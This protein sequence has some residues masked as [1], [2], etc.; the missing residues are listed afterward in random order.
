[1]RRT[2]ID[3]MA[4]KNI[5]IKPIINYSLHNHLLSSVLVCNFLF[6]YRVMSMV[7]CWLIFFYACW[8]QSKPISHQNV[9][10]RR[11]SAQLS[12]GIG[13]HWPKT[14][15]FVLKVFLLFTILL[16]IKKKLYYPRTLLCFRQLLLFV[17]YIII[18]F[19]C[20]IQC[21]NKIKDFKVYNDNI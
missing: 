14:E 16:L 9:N 18:C 15:F 3:F 19:P 8:G 10:M 12:R 17:N 1:M 21:W 2:S 20:I 13:R 7:V 11:S 5:L 4:N 6:V